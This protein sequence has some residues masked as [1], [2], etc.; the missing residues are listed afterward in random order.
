MVRVFSPGI[1]GTLYCVLVLSSGFYGTPLPPVFIF[2]SGLSGS[3]Y[4]VLDFT[5]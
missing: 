3:L 1:S 5:F 2:S 4:I